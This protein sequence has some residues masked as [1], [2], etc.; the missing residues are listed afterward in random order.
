M[1]QRDR[2]ALTKGWIVLYRAR[3]HLIIDMRGKPKSAIVDQ[4][5]ALR[6]LWAVEDGS[7]EGYTAL[8]LAK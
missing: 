6:V 8:D 2:D 4:D 1:E 7:Y 5:C 3:C